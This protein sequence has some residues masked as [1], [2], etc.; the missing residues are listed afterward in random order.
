MIDQID[1][2]NM[3]RIKKWRND[4][5][6][7]VI[8]YILIFCIIYM[9][10]SDPSNLR[11]FISSIGST[12]IMVSFLVD[13]GKNTIINNTIKTITLISLIVDIIFSTHSILNY[14]GTS[15][16]LKDVF[17]ISRLKYITSFK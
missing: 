15:S 5:V 13:I 10:N 2:I 1:Y 14:N 11:R 17:G 16:L 9:I 12:G 6:I 4:P 3:D 8:V 7:I